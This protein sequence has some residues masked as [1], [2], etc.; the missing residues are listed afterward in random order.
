MKRSIL[1]ASAVAILL[2]GGC[3]IVESD[4]YSYQTDTKIPIGFTYFLPRVMMKIEASRTTVT[5]ASVASKAQKVATRN[6]AAAV[7]L[8]A[9]NKAG[10]ARIEKKGAYDKAKADPNFD[11]AALAALKKDYEKANLEYFK[12]KAVSDYAKSLAAA[13]QADLEAHRNN[14]NACIRTVTLTRLPIEADTDNHYVAKL[15]HVWTRSDELDIKSNE[16]GLLESTDLTSE[17]KLGE[18][19]VSIAKLVLRAQSLVALPPAEIQDMD[20][21]GST[22][23]CKRYTAGWIFDP[24]DMAATSSTMFAINALLQRINAKLAIQAPISHNAVAKKSS[25]EGLYYRRPIPY[26]F[27]VLIDNDQVQ[28][29]RET[30][31]NNG[32]IAIASLRAGAFVKTTR[33]LKFINGMLISDHAIRPSEGLGVL[34]IPAG[35]L[36]AITSPE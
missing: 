20:A 29:S 8:A 17:D 36:D 6:A 19:A 7:A 28:S 10:E 11:A 3:A 22:P 32:P 23:T 25:A 26:Q 35:I 13:A 21:T 15:K 30:L 24:A 1:G 4:T 33:N 18:I 14:L 9:T 27:D 5:V 31:P 12:K 16:L 2:V 34:K